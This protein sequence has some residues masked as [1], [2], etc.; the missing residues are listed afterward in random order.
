[1]Y[2]GVK[3]TLQELEKFEATID[4]V[5]LDG[6][7]CTVYMYIQCIHVHVVPLYYVLVFLVVY[8]CMYNVHD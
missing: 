8:M 3:P 6:G 4:D 7:L 2:D 5:D 1:M